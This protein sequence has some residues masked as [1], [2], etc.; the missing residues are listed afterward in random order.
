MNLSL[1]P[2]VQRFIDELI[3]AGRF[4]TPEAVIEA[5]ISDMRESESL[6]L[7]D[8]T[9][10]AINEAEAQADRGEGT[11]LDTF[12]VDFFKRVNGR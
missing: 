12:R 2:D 4:P 8:E 5:A 7:D 1:A 9:A 11:D 6:D 10:A 3:R